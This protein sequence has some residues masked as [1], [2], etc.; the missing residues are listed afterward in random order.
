MPEGLPR[1]LLHLAEAH[2]AAGERDAAVRALVRRQEVLPEPKGALR[3]LGGRLGLA[4]DATFE[5]LVER[6]RA[7]WRSG[8]TPTN[9]ECRARGARA[10]PFVSRPR[11]R[12]CGRGP[13]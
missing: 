1:A 12:R 2:A 5:Q 10:A 13:R 3:A 8:R 9:D 4:G 7:P 6:A 11:P